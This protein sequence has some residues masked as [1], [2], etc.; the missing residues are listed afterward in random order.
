MHPT[1]NELAQ[2]GSASTMFKKFT[3]V[4]ALV[5]LATAATWSVAGE[6]YRDVAQV[7][8]VQPL[9]RSV[10][11]SN[12][13]QRCWDEPVT[14]QERY[15][16][17]GYGHGHQRR[18]R[19]YTGPIV[20]GVVGGLIGNQF[21]GGDGRALLTVAGAVLGASIGNDVGHRSHRRHRRHHRGHN[22]S[23]ARTYTTMQRHC[24]TSQN[25]SQRQ[26]RDGYLVQYRYKGRVY[27]TRLDY[28]PGRQLDV[29]VQVLPRR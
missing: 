6:T 16:D 15:V 17:N 28:D 13:V 7:V 4:A 3:Q 21:G 18:G 8:S 22:H 23:S 24:S 29:D 11:V 25:V 27:D 5:G 10:Q 1:L 14:V 19:S 12:P 9:F 26:E 2:L 20:G